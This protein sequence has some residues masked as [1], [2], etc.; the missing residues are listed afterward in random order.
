MNKTTIDTMNW[1]YGVDGLIKINIYVTG[2]SIESIKIWADFFYY[3][4]KII[5]IEFMDITDENNV[6]TD[7][8]PE[9]R[10]RLLVVITTHIC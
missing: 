3:Y 6:Y 2:E 1:W 7:P 9:D 5:K 10:I 8:I 4:K